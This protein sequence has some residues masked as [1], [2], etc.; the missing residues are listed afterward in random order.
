MSAVGGGGAT[1]DFIVWFSPDKPQ[2]PKHSLPKRPT[3]NK[4]K[5][6]RILPLTRQTTQLRYIIVG[7]CYVTCRFLCCAD[8]CSKKSK[9]NVNEIIETST[10]TV[11]KSLW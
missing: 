4:D 9:V 8:F 1:I 2:V 10:N 11:Q 7:N 5:S 6:L 3:T